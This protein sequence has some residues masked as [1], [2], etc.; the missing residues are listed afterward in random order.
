MP[1][2]IY[3]R[4]ALI[5]LLPVVV[6]QVV[7]SVV[8]TQRHF[9]DVTRQMTDTMSRELRL[10]VDTVEGQADAITGASVVATTLAPLNIVVASAAALAPAARD[11]SNWYDF[12]GRTIRARV[13]LGRG[14]VWTGAAHLL[15]ACGRN[16]SAGGR[17]RVCRYAQPD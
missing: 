7:V 5:L 17:H 15:C 16:R 9:E 12:S 8:F 14:G 13:R 3:A 10:V 1:R 11:T 4:A 6:L 2:G